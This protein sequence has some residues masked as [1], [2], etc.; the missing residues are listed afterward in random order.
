MVEMLSREEILKELAPV[1]L[2]IGGKKM[3]VSEA[4]LIF[5]DL[6]IGG[7]D[8]AELIE[9]VHARYGTRFEGFKYETYFPNEVEDFWEYVGS[10]FGFKRTER[11]HFWVGHLIDVI[12][13]GAWFEPPAPPST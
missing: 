6:T 7:D 12:Q 11:K 3:P 8:A 13:K 5:H 2:K 4:T 10:L 1:L 9:E